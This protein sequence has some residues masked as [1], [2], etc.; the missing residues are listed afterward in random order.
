MSI[1][2]VI[3]SILKSSVELKALVGEKIYPYAIEEDDTLPGVL[4]KINSIKPEYDKSGLVQDKNEVEI[5]AYAKTYS[6]L[7]DVS[8][9]IRKALELIKGEIVNITVKSSRVL[10]YYESYDL[11]QDIYFSRINFLI[12]TQ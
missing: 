6:S 1:G 7:L 9:E 2:K 8:S 4:Y 10:D 11:V 3:N 5:L 12:I